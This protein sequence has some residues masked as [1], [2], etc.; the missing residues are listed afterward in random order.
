MNSEIVNFFLKFIQSEKRCSQHTYLAYGN[1]MNQFVSYLAV[2]YDFHH[3]EMADHQ[4]IR[5]WIVSLSEAKLE[6]RSI[7]RKIAT[8]RTF[9][10]FLL[11][12]KIIEKDPMVK[13]SALK[14]P[15]NLPVFVR[16]SE[17]DNLLDNITFEA[18]FEGTRDKLI[19]E[20]LYGSGMRLSELIELKDTDVDFYN[21]TLKVL[22]KR[23]KQR[24][25]PVNQQLLSLIQGYLASKSEEGL[26]CEYLIVS[27][28]GEK[29]YPGLIQRI[30]KKYLSL[31]TTLTKKSPHVLRHSYATHLLNNGADLNA[32]KDL[33]GHSSL[34][35][36]QVYTHNSI[37]KIK[38][39]Y[40]Q[41]H[42]KA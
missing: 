42:P 34:S 22:G 4:M 1:D 3:P 37:E 23:N 40:E 5:S 6:N 33:L 24:I 39:I 25:I 15:K 2:S 16:E 10:N 7:N 26:S 17:M 28:K 13:V 41:A 35:A 38:K 36:T 32:I 27:Q 31:V 11:R 14:T 12:K 18:T 30:T 20:L 19:L 8:L 9:Y 29:S 21:K